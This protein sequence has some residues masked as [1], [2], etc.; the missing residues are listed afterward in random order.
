[1]T[2]YLNRMPAGIT[3]EVS[4]P[5]ATLESQLTG[6]TAI[7]FGAVVKIK[8]GK[9][10]ALEQGD[11]AD[12]IYGFLSRVYPTT[13]AAT[14]F[15]SASAAPGTLQSVM[16]RGYMIVPLKG[17]AQDAKADPVYVRTSAESL[18][19]IGEIEAGAGEGLVAIPGCI[20]MGAEDADG[21][22]EISFNI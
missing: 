15:G 11:T 18:E 2:A 16:R 6:A 3:G 19:T 14:N 8:N 20:F 9:L 5:G 12:V 21:A 13:S 10:S 7:P 4:R 22:V 1:M 17:S